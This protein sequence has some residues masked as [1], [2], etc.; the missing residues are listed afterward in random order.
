MWDFFVYVNDPMTSINDVVLPSW[1]DE[2]HY[3]QLED[4]EL[5]YKGV[6]VEQRCLEQTPKG[7]T[8]GAWEQSQLGT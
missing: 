4:Y 1:S 6:G 3:S 7:H 5:N 8:L 2:W